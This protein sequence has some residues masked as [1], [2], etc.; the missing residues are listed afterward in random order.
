MK[1]K[2]IGNLILLAMV[3][4]LGLSFVDFGK[5]DRSFQEQI[6]AFI[7]DHLAED[8]DYSSLS[9]EEINEEFLMVRE[10]ISQPLETVGDTI[11]N[12][13]NLLKGR[14]I[15][16]EFQKGLEKAEA[17][18]ASLKLET[19]A[20]YLAI[21]AQIKRS[22]KESGELDAIAKNGLYRE[23]SRMLDAINELNSALG[24]F[25]LS[26]FSVDFNSASV[27]YYHEYQL[28]D[29]FGS[30]VKSAVFELDR[31][32]KEVISFKELG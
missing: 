4:G 8:T 18:L 32:S 14:F 28:S 1:K 19:V 6:S 21:D 15:S 22:L 27:S 5:K 29:D 20:D 30:S 23:E 13:L 31:E 7:L 25:N 17:H 24:E 9:L 2:L 26:I 10:A 16:L 11:R 3:V 12:Q